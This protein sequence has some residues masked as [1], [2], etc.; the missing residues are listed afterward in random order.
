MNYM[1]IGIFDPYLDDLGGGEKYMMTIA[2]VLSEKNEVDV[3]WDNKSDLD[4]LLKRFSLDLSRVKI[5]PNI[6]SPKFSTL[7]RFLASRK[8]DRVIFLSDGSIPLVFPKL[9]VHIQQPLDKLQSNT[10]TGKLKVKRVNVFFCNSNYTKSFIDEKFHLKTKILFPPVKI[11]STNEKKE[12]IILHVGRFRIKNVN[13]DDYKKQHIMVS[14]FKKMVDKGLKGW[15]FVL[16]VSVNEKAIKAF[17]EMKSFAKNYP[18]EFLVNKSN[19][20]LWETYSRAK[21]YWH[22]SGYGEDLKTHPEFAEHFGISTVEAMGAGAVP[23]VINAGGQKE[24]VK[25]ADNGFLWDTLMELQT[26]TLKLINNEKLL[27]DLSK[28]AKEKAKD[29]SEENFSET[30]NG[31]IND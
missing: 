28:N 19:D 2:Q 10:L 31:F 13:N 17:E 6:F 23:V 5:V 15:K 3:F 27:N 16:A 29:F 9:L 21:I 14:E 11:K 30:V 25:D 18:I 22:A 4:G 12:N 7:Q 24:I 20:A 8:Y 1:R 26:K